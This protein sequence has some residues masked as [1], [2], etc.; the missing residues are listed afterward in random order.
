MDPIILGAAIVAVALAAGKK[1]PAGGAT[2]TADGPQPD[3][4][5]PDGR[6]N[7]VDGSASAVSMDGSTV[8]VGHDG[9]GV[10]ITNDTGV[11]S[12]APIA[13][14]MGIAGMGLGTP[15]QDHRGERDVGGVAINAAG[16]AAAGSV[17]GVLGLGG[18][19]AS[20]AIRIGTATSLGTGIVTKRDAARYITDFGTHMGAIW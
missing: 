4:T 20:E 13:R 10:T 1:A 14:P 3:Y 2:V 7:P 6:N 16:D 12:D 5:R 18:L 9:A 15:T 17:T 19:P 8:T 11:S